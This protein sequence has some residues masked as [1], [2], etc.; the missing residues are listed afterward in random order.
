MDLLL[1]TMK[2]YPVLWEFD[3]QPFNEDYYEAVEEICQII[4]NKWSLKVDN[5]K[6]RRSINR[7]LRFYC[8]LYPLQNIENINEY[9][10]YYDKCASFLPASIHDIAYARCSHCYKC[11]E[12]DSELRAHLLDE[13]NRNL[14]WPYKCVLCKECYTD[15]DD[16]DFHQS[17]I[18]YQEIFRCKYCPRTFKARNKF[19]L[20]VNKH[21]LNENG[22]D[23]GKYVCKICNKT[24]PNKSRLSYHR[25]YHTEKKHKCHLCDKSFWVN[26]FLVRHLKTHRNEYELM[27]EV[28][29]KGFQY[30][31]N[32][33]EHMKKHTGAKI[34]CN[35]CNLRLRRSSLNRHLRTVHVACEGTIESTYR[36]RNFHFRRIL[37]PKT[38]KCKR[39]KI[40]NKEKYYSCKICNIQFERFK[41]ILEHNKE[42]HNDGPRYN[43]Q[44]CGSE[45]GK[46]ITLKHHYRRKHSMHPYQIYR[47]VDR[48]DDINEVMSMKQEELDRISETASYSLY[49]PPKPPA[50]PEN[51]SANVVN[52]PNET[53]TNNDDER[54]LIVKEENPSANEMSFEEERLHSDTIQDQIMKATD[55]IVA[56]DDI[57]IDDDQYMSDLLKMF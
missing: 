50:S 57:K 38:D 20:H 2:N 22:G 5:L 19:N 37:R 43:C 31:N 16:Y 56:T 51:F 36:A 29:G 11:F 46:K 40:S 26:S 55:N 49:P 3:A 9:T 44:L 42:F 52:E 54:I 12:N 10:F 14:G 6:M 4:N 53:A 28:C 47:I 13:Q 17:L 48:N 15:K 1:D 23:Q 34:T 7:I 27:C 24:F 30:H 33:R 32:L 35:I 21:K 18:H 41:F 8:S 39:K 45:V 25:K